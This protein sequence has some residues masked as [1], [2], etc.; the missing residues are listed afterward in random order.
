MERIKVKSL[1]PAAKLPA[2]MTAGAAGF[3][4]YALKAVCIMPQHRC[5]IHTGVA[6]ELPD[7]FALFLMARSSMGADGLMLTNGV[8]LVDGDYAGEI[9]FSYRNVGTNP[10]SVDAGHRIGQGVLIP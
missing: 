3:D 4:F 2:Y 5:I 1:D 6:L 7:G 10:I 9:M 8:G